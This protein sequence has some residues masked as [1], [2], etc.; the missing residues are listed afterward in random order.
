MKE[1]IERIRSLVGRVRRNPDAGSTMT[2]LALAEIADCLESIDERLQRMERIADAPPTVIY[3]DS[4]SISKDDLEV[5]MTSPSAYRLTNPISAASSAAKAHAVDW[6]V[7]A[8][9]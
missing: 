7:G 9:V 5:L 4:V 1:K 8:K 3:S 2:V 6:A